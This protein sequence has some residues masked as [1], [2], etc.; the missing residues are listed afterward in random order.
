MGNVVSS[1]ESIKPVLPLLVMSQSSFGIR[2]HVCLCEAFRKK[3]ALIFEGWCSI[4]SST[5]F[6]FENLR[7]QPW[8]C[9]HA[10]HPP[11]H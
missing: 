10:P 1:V 3:G 4:L 5:L 6:S 2:T 9:H 11:H 7:V 8:S